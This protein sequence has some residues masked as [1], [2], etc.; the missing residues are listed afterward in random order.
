MQD[1][2]S[3]D[4]QI[5]Y[6]NSS[7]LSAGGSYTFPQA[8][9]SLSFKI[10][11]V[12]DFYIWLHFEL[13]SGDDANQRFYVQWDGRNIQRAGDENHFSSN[14][15]SVAIPYSQLVKLSNNQSNEISHFVMSTNNGYAI[16]LANGRGEAISFYFNVEK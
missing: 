5:F 9:Q 16:K 12:E 13:K 14:G 11:N 8:N 2:S 1:N 7:E 6:N 3:S 4:N 10:D 15:M